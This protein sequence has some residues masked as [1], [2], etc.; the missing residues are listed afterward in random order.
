MESPDGHR[1]SHAGGATIR[2]KLDGQQAQC[3]PNQ[4]GGLSLEVT[5]SEA[6]GGLVAWW[7]GAG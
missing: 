7:S 5:K 3:V 2:H 6:P 4:G 1:R